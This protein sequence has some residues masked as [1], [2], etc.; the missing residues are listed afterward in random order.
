MDTKKC[1]SLNSYD[2][3]FYCQQSEN[4]SFS[5]D[6]TYVCSR[7]WFW[8]ILVRIIISICENICIYVIA[9]IIIFTFYLYDISTQILKKIIQTNIIVQIN[10]HIFVTIR[11][12]T[13]ELQHFGISVAKAFGFSSYTVNCILASSSDMQC[14]IS[15]LLRWTTA[16]FMLS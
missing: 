4:C 3:S 10:N 5:I 2:I 11:W 14:H 8:L 13:M 12:I 1:S 7:V 15:D 6:I 9:C 16:Y